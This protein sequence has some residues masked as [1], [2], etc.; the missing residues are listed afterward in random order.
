VRLVDASFLIDYSKGGKAAVRYLEAHDGGVFGASTI[1][2]SEVYR[3]LIIHRGM[4]REEARTKYGWAR[5]VPFTADAAGEAADI[6]AQ[7]RRDGTMIPR[8]DIYIA[9]TARAFELPIVT[10]DE[11]FEHVDELDVEYY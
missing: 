9:G 8:S 3:G 2:L 7:L 6:Y 1:V 4:S 5:D 11:H 10:A